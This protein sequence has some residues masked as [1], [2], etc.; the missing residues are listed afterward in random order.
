MRSLALLFCLLAAL[1]VT[2]IAPQVGVLL[3]C[4]LSFMS[5][6][7]FAYLP[8]PIPMVYMVAV[9]TMVAWILSHDPKRLPANITPWLII[10]F[11]IDM[12]LTSTVSIS[13]VTVWG[14][15]NRNIKTMVLALAIMA[16]MTNR[17]RIQAMVWTMVL[18]IGFY[19]VKGAIFV[20]LTG[21]AHRVEGPYG[22]M[23]ADNNTL[24]LAMIMVWPL[25]YYLR[26]SSDDRR[27]R[28]GL[29]IAMGLSVFAIL[30]TYSRGAVVAFSF[31]VIYFW[32]KSRRKVVFGALGV[33]VIV[34]ALFFMP[35]EWFDRMNTINTYDQDSSA[36]GRLEAWGIALRIAADRPLTGVGFDAMV[37]PQATQ[38]YAPD[39]EIPHVA[40]SIWFEPLA[41][42][43]IPGFIIFVTI[44]LVGLVQANSVRK[45]TKLLPDWA[46]AHDLATM[47]QL[48]LAGYFV[49]G[50]FLSMPYYDLYYG[51]IATISVLYDYVRRAERSVARNPLASEAYSIASTRPAHSIRPSPHVT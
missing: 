19:A 41:D 17:V 14:L 7:A 4:W 37:T 15:W 23:I 35:S 29:L 39:R 13:P 46:W 32:W 49:A 34:P 20:L 24:G 42:H 25:M 5:P 10:L 1:P 8:I 18:A 22:T 27:I 50:T 12:T 36:M 11:I 16:I 51:M 47:S 43:G 48:S 44:G 21:G 9:V 33:L 40:H 28:A 2:L 26:Q 38:L 45:R 30:G 6:Q 3:W 31:T